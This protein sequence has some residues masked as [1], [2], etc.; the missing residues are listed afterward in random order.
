[1]ISFDFSKYAQSQFKKLPKSEQKRIIRKLEFF[2]STP[3]PLSLS[4][5]LSKDTKEF[6]FIASELVPGE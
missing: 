6:L 4:P 3:N 1:M 5:N 2:L